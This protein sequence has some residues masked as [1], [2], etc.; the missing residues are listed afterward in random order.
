MRFRRAVSPAGSR[1]KGRASPGGRGIRRKALTP[2]VVIGLVLSGLGLYF[3]LAQ[4]GVERTLKIGFQKSPPYHFPDANGSPTGPAVEVVKEAARRKNILLQW[5][6]SS[7][8][9]EKAL[10]AGTVDLWLMRDLPERRPFL[11]ISAPSVPIFVLTEANL[12]AL[13]LGVAGPLP[14]LGSML[15][16]LQGYS[17]VAARPYAIAPAV[18]LA[19]SVTILEYVVSR[20]E[21]VS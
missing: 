4:D 11:Y 6:Y 16:K 9:P 1:S 15:R 8:G 17:G 5:I 19:V 18:V 20:R 7:E 13:G 21:V 14:S 12:G 2:V 10:G 3:H